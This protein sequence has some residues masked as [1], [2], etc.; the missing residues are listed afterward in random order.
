MQTSRLLVFGILTFAF[1]DCSALYADLVHRWSF[2]QPAGAISSGTTLADSVGNAVATVRGI[3]AQFSG[4]TL[5]LPGTTNGNQSPSLISAYIDL[6]NGII[7][8]KTHL[9]VEIWA[10]PLSYQ[11]FQRLF[12]FG[13]IAQAGDGLGAP[14]EITGLA[15]TAPG[16]TSSY[17]GF[18]LTLSRNTAGNVN[19]Q[20]FETR[21]NGVGAGDTTGQYGI[22]DTNVATTVGTE[23]HYVLTFQSG[24]VLLPPQVGGR[25]GIGMGCWLRR[26]TQAFDSTKFKTST[27]GW[28]VRIGV[29]IVERMLPTTKCG[30]MTMP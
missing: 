28:G 7:S 23:Y 8:S 6:P 12:D 17:E 25:H 4:T 3:G 30:F 13:R 27:T 14:G 20:R 10:T 21:L 16:T 22:A 11:Q 15:S 9:T 2:N 19:E 26:S 1:F 18:T 24:E 29:A 5:S